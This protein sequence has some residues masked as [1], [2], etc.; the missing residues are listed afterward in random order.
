[1]CGPLFEWIFFLTFKF[2][3]E[4]PFLSSFDKWP[5]HKSKSILHVNLTEKSAEEMSSNSHPDPEATQ[6]ANDMANVSLQMI[7]QQLRDFRQENGG[8]LREIKED[9]KTKNSRV[10]EA[11][12]RISEAE[13]RLQVMEEAT[14]ELLKPQK[15]PGARLTDQ[16][17]RSRRENIIIV[18]PCSGN[19]VP[20]PL[21]S[22]LQVLK[23]KKK[24]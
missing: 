1:M 21:L 22:G 16:E 20:D 11:E 6:E 17:E 18:E 10:D 15:K 14:T 24:F 9:I 23:L 13:D 4:T 3:E 8:A 19:L 5:R 7:L 12:N 2:F